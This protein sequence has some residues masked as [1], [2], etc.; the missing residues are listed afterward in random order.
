MAAFTLADY[1]RR[2]AEPQGHLT[3]AQGELDRASFQ[4]EVGEIGTDQRDR[5]RAGLAEIES[6]LRGLDGAARTAATRQQAHE[7][8]ADHARRTAAVRKVKDLLAE[9]ASAVEAMKKQVRGLGN[10]CRQSP[11][12]ARRSLVSA[13]S[14]GAT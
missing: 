12:R 13:S 6:R 11:A 8:A 2:K 1:P 3:A 9:R 7:A 5:A 14:T 10:I 4:F